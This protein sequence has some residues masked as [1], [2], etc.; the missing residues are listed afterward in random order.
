MLNLRC[1]FDN[2]EAIDY[3]QQ[4]RDERFLTNDEAFLS[5]D[6]YDDSDDEALSFILQRARMRNNPE[7]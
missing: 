4:V 3:I 6:D 7:S 1:R 5:V 2:V